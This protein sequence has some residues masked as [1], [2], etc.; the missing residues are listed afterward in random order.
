[1]LEYGIK[2]ITTNP[3]LITKAS[4][5][6]RLVDSRSHKTRAFVLP[7]SYEPIIEKLSKEMEFRSWIEQKKKKINKDKDNLDDVMEVGIAS[8]SDYLQEDK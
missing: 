7:V 4:E 3:T 5:I 6:I 2:A 1:M 8:M